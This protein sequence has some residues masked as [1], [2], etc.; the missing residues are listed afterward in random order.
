M[1]IDL[2]LFDMDDVLCAYDVPRRLGEL[3]RLSGRSVEAV[4]AAIWDSGFEHAADEG[5]IDAQGYLEGFGARLG[6]PL[7]R[8]E[9]V[10][11]RRIA[12]TPWPDMLA[13]AEALRATGRRIAVLSNNGLLT[14]ETIN[15]MF[16]A[17]RPVFGP[18]IFMS[19]QFRATKPAPEV[20]H[21]ALSRLGAAPERTLFFDD[22]AENV[23]GARA[24]GLDAEVFAGVAGFDAHLARRGI[25]LA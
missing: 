17:L 2:V 13:R 22:K 8:D 21:G 7:S 10:A 14:A 25:V 6:R 3:S 24:A 12:M 1:P 11:A 4:H 18:D 23:A 20:F 5:A 9:W 16:P 15:E 19:A